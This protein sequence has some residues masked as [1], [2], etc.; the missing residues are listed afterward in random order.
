MERKKKILLTNLSISGP[1]YSG[2][3]GEKNKVNI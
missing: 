1:S 3:R 2:S